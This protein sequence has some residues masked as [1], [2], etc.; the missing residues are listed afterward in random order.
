MWAWE[1]AWGCRRA[2]PVA[3]GRPVSLPFPEGP[4]SARLGVQARSPLLKVRW[5][6]RHQRWAGGRASCCAPRRPRGAHPPPAWGASVRQRSAK[7]LEEGWRRTPSRPHAV[8]CPARAAAYG[9]GQDRP[10]TVQ[11]RPPLSPAELDAPVPSPPPTRP[12]RGSFTPRGLPRAR[13]SA[14]SLLDPALGLMV[15]SA[16]LRGPRGGCTGLLS[17]WPSPSCSGPH[18][19]WPPRGS[20]TRTSDEACP[21]ASG[22]V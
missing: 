20:V 11:P 4:A 19:S 13:R 21:R 1:G 17:C 6:Q 22:F 7:R 16:C 14:P 12:P 9:A 3:G 18:P 2:G 8:P 5:Q 10:D 15:R